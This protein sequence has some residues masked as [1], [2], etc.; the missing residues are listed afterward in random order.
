M[1]WEH[2]SQASV[3]TAFSSQKFSLE[4]KLS[5]FLSSVDFCASSFS[6]GIKFY[7][8]ERISKVSL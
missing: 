4:T 3:S 1:L 2:E 8:I 6:V 5:D 7:F